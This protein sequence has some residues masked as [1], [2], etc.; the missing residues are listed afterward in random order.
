[1]N[2]NS[3]IRFPPKPEYSAPDFNNA[4][5]GLKSLPWLVWRAEPPKPGTTK[6]RKVP[7]F[8]SGKAIPKGA[9]ITTWGGSFDVA[10]KTYQNSQKWPRPFDGIGFVINGETGP[11]GLTRCGI[12]FDKITPEDKEFI[13]QLNTY[14]ETSPS[15]RGVHCISWAKPFEQ[16]TCDVN[17]FKTEA[18]SRG[19]YFTF[20]GLRVEGSP[21]EPQTRPDEV[22]K[23]VAAIQLRKSQQGKAQAKHAAA[24]AGVAD[25]IGNEDNSLMSRVNRGQVRGFTPKA[26]SKEFANEPVEPLTGGDYGP[27]DPTKL[28]SAL[29]WLHALMVSEDDWVKICISLANEVRRH[30]IDR[31]D[32][33]SIEEQ[34]WGILDK[35][36]KGA[37]EELKPIFN[38]SIC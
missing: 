6:W 9:P 24:A 15:G 11:N 8:A 3:V 30:Q 29:G 21:A 37:A 18:Y 5:D 12:D 27:P 19:R 2:T 35:H 25:L 13:R 10:T 20:T 1:M 17:A 28:D 23:I 7:Y 34:I 14:T 16:A 4:P 36:S 31:P 26:I 32:E 33:P 38:S 22:A